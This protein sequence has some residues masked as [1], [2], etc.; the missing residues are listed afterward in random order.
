MEKAFLT[1]LSETWYSVALEQNQEEVLWLEWR[2]VEKDEAAD[3]CMGGWGFHIV[4][5]G[6][7]TTGK[8]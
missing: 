7:E 8:Y 6:L 1:E 5:D 3:A 2:H 4:L